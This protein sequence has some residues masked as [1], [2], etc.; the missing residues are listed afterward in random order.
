MATPI[1]LAGFGH[2]TF[3]LTGYSTGGIPLWTALF[4]TGI[5]SVAGR[6]G[7]RA[8]RVTEDGANATNVGRLFPTPPS[9]L[10]ASGWIRLPSGAPSAASVALRLPATTG[11][12][13]HLRVNASGVLQLIWTDGTGSQDGPNIAD[14]SWHLVELLIDVSGATSTANWRVDGTAYTQTTKSQSADTISQFIFGSTIAS[15][16][17][18]VEHDDW[19]FSATSGDYPIGPCIV[20]ELHPSSDGTHNDGGNFTSTGTAGIYFEDVDDWASGADDGSTTRI[21]QLTNGSGN[22]VEVAFDDLASGDSTVHGALAVAAILSAST[23]SNLA[24]TRIVYADGST[25]VNVF[26]GDQSDT[27]SRYQA[28]LVPAPGGG[29]SKT[30]AD[31]LRLRFG[32]SSDASPDPYLTAALIEVAVAEAA[33]Q[34]AAIGAAA[35]ADTAQ[36]LARAK[37]RATGAISEPDSSLPLGKAKQAGAGTAAQTDGAQ[38]LG[39]AKS[40][41]LGV[42]LDAHQAGSLGKVKGVGMAQEI[43]DAQALGASKGRAVGSSAEASSSLHLGGAKATARGLAGEADTVQALGQGK[44]RALT[45]SPET[46]GAQGLAA[47]KDAGLGTSTEFDA[48]PSAGQAKAKTAGLA[49]EADDALVITEAGGITQPISAAIDASLAPSMGAA[50]SRMLIVP[51][52]ASTAVALAATKARQLL[53]AAETS[54]ALGLLGAKAQTFGV[55]TELDAAAALTV[56]AP[57]GG[58]IVAS[59]VTADIASQAAGAE[60]RGGASGSDS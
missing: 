51:L 27:A 48:S 46:D 54:T 7:G 57:A 35:E 10:V 31:G 19:V 20:R 58:D 34:S 24:T 14:G 13:I 38:G 44:A 49:A 36:V 33:G 23:A 59:V 12:G 25:A 43:D 40:L 9:V 42:A 29:W 50:K 37:A 2:R 8:L 32:F 45:I 39:R 55:A 26:S 28:A 52:E 60:T 53:L 17:L 21:A 5:S 18:T 16:D 11:S 41:A 22:Y 6:T 3:S 4:G 56:P 30:A 1:W 47:A 15:H